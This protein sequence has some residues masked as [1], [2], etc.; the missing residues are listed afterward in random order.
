MSYGHSLERLQEKK[1]WFKVFLPSHTF[2]LDWL[3]VNPGHRNISQAHSLFI[4]E[5][6]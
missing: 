2:K 4:N 6:A 3:K 5:K 1:Y